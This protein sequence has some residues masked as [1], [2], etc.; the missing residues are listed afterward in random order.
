MVALNVYPACTMSRTNCRRLSAMRTQGGL[1]LV[2]SIKTPSP[3]GQRDVRRQ[4]QGPA[5]VRP[6]K[7]TTAA[8]RMSTHS[9]SAALLR[10]PQGAPRGRYPR[11]TEE[12]VARLDQTLPTAPE[13]P[14]RSTLAAHAAELPRLPA[15][16]LPLPRSTRPH[17]RG[18]LLDVTMPKV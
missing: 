7:C 6:A 3:S 2:G 17:P 11:L 18:P 15:A 8:L 5:L 16:L 14:R 9:T 10:F 13:P 12:H 1:A 4:P